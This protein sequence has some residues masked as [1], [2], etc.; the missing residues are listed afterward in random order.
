[1]KKV[2][3]FVVALSFAT[4]VSAQKI[5]LKA[6]VNLATQSL[7]LDNKKVD[8][9]KM[10]LGYQVGAIV[11]M[12]I[13]PLELE[14]NLLLSAKGSKL[15]KETNIMGISSKATIKQSLLYLDIPVK[16][17][18][19]MDL[20]GLGVF[21]GVGPTFGYGIH[22]KTKS[23]STTNSQSL[24]N[25]S[26]IKWGSKV[27][28]VKPFS[29]GLGFQGGVVLMDK[30]RVGAS[31]DMGLSNMSNVEKTSHKNSVFTIFAAYMF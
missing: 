30:I 22:G 28:E 11:T 26:K 25:D 31:Y 16:V 7:K 1:M 23:K 27:D 6:G 2:F 10:I 4:V 12:P 29:I 8:G 21:V 24:E 18:Y 3:L 20:G 13:G 5:G 17:N 15:E 14:A 19:V 9:N